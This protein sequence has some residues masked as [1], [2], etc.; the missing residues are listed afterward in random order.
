MPRCNLKDR[1]R[2][3]LCEQRKGTVTSTS[4]SMKPKAQTGCP[5]GII[6]GFLMWGC[7]RYLYIVS[8]L[9]SVDGRQHPL[10]PGEAG[11]STGAGA[12]G[13]SA[14]DWEAAERSLAS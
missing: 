12:E 9:P 10:H 14:V 1:A 5:E 3:H 8:V 2:V 13:C 4:A 7:M 11:N 6:Q